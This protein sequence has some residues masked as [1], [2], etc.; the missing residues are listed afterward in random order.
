MVGAKER[1]ERRRIYVIIHHVGIG[2]IQDV[3]HANARGPAISMKRELPF[4]RG[5]HGNEIREAELP[6]T[7]N[8]LPELVNR[9]KAEPGP[10]YA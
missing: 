8:D 2:A 7:R 4:Y 6:R 5:V 10:P 1:Q 3:I 9:Y